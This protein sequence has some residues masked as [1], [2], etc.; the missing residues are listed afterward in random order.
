MVNC[1]EGIEERIIDSVEEGKIKKERGRMEIEIDKER[2]GLSKLK[3]E[4]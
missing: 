1:E 3:I 4:S 2:K